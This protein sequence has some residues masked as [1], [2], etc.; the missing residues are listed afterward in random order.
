[1]VP[2]TPAAAPLCTLKSHDL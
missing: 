2:P 1:M